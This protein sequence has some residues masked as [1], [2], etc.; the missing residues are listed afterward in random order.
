MKRSIPCSPPMSH[1]SILKLVRLVVNLIPVASRVTPLI[2]S[3]VLV[4]SNDFKC[5]LCCNMM[6]ARCETSFMVLARAAMESLRN[7]SFLEHFRDRN[8]NLDLTISFTR[9]HEASCLGGVSIK[10][11]I[12][13]SRRFVFCCSARPNASYRFRRKEAVCSEMSQC[14][15][16]NN[17]SFCSPVESTLRCVTMVVVVVVVSD[18][19]EQTTCFP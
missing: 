2:S 6:D 18:D 7:T 3:V 9:E 1:P 14:Q 15:D 4:T 12:T 16:V 11:F 17:S 5:W 19:Y 8:S 10:L 13:S